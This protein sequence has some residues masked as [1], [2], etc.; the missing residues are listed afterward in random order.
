MILF[1]QMQK[2]K[3][4]LMISSHVFQRVIRGKIMDENIIKHMR[5]RLLEVPKREMQ[6]DGSIIEIYNQPERLNPTDH[7]VESN[8]MVCDSLNTANK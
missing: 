4:V 7:I 6:S 8:E 1:S 2:R 5:Q 3:N